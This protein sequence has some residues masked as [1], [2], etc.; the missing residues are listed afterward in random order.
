MKIRNRSKRA[1]IRGHILMIILVLLFAYPFIYMVSTSFKSMTEIFRSGLNLIPEKFTLE[2][3]ESVFTKLPVASYLK[4]SFIIAVIAMAAK[5]TTSVLASYALVFMNFKGKNALFY[6]FSITMFIP[7]TVIIL[8]NYLTVNKLGLLSTLL[9]VALPQMADAMGILRIRQA[10][11]SIPR[12]LVEAARIDKVSHFTA[13]TRIVVPLTRPAISAMSILFFINSWNEYFWPLLIL[14]N[15][16]MSTITLALQ[17]FASGES[18]NAWGSSMALAT[19]ATVI[20]LVL[21]LVFQRQIIGTFM[22]SGI[23][24]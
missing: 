17:Q 20:P 2:N 8:P 18:G 7:F 12:S 14:K 13:L 1:A 4:N 16:N 10:M 19:V 5:V 24:E 11:R 21:Y 23:K 9:G 22:S 15:K 6:F 3:Y